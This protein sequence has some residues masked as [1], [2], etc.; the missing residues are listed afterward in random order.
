M[1]EGPVLPEFAEQVSH[2]ALELAFQAS[3][4]PELKS[5]KAFDGG[6]VPLVVEKEREV[7][8]EEMLSLLATEL[9]TIMFWKLMTRF[10][11]SRATM[12]LVRVLSVTDMSEAPSTRACIVDPWNDS[13]KVWN[14]VAS[15]V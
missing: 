15:N 12:P 6:L 14:C 11:T 3:T 4:P 1:I 9:L 13:S 5:C 7:G 2:E 8:I 10:D